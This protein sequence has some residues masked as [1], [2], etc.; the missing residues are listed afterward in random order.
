M[1]HLNANVHLKQKR[2]R[3]ASVIILLL[4]S[5]TSNVQGPS[6]AFVVVPKINRAKTSETIV[7]NKN[8]TI[9]VAFL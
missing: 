2:R 8:Q 5:I 6:Q 9:I 3:V 1:L 4:F 7:K